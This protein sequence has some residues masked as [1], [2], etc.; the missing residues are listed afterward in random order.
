MICYLRMHNRRV[1]IKMPD[2]GTLPK[3][4]RCA[5]IGRMIGLRSDEMEPICNKLG[6]PVARAGTGERKIKMASPKLFFEK[7]QEV[8]EI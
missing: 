1:P 2:V 4:M 5:A 3:M 6:V 8:G 7:L